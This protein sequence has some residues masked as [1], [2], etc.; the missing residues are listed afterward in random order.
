LFISLPLVLVYTKVAPKKRSLRRGRGANQERA[1]GGD[2]PDNP[3]L[4]LVV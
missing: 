2:A 1:L 4:T 3:C